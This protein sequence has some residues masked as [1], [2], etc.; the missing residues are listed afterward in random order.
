MTSIDIGG[1]S[2]DFAAKSLKIAETATA[3]EG[4]VQVLAL[5]AATGDLL[6]RYVRELP[7]EAQ[8]HR[9]KVNRSVALYGDK[10]YVGTSG[11]HV[12]ALD[13]VTGALAW[14]QPV[15]DPSAGYYIT[16]APLT[17]AGKVMVGVSGGGYGI[18]GFVTALDAETGV[19]ESYH[20]YHHNG[21]WDWDE[22][23]PPLVLDI[24]RNGR[25]IPALVHPAR[26]GYLWFLERSAAGIG[27]VGAVPS[28][29]RLSS[30][31]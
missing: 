28:F 7:A 13:A 17:V 11:A 16:M 23:A 2:D 19:I 5:E 12:V 21:S 24:E 25:T 22:S 3:D 9:N 8:M 15:A 14:E 29:I 6:W 10:V 4:G 1:P 27:F 30:R 31:P 20:Q 18:R 26:N